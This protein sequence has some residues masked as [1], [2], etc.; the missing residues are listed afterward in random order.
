MGSEMCIRDS[1]LDQRHACT[2]IIEELRTP[3]LGANIHQIVRR[4]GRV[5][6]ELDLL[7]RHLQGIVFVAE[8]SVLEPDRYRARVC[9]W[10]CVSWCD[11]LRFCVIW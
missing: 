4:L 2:V 3:L 8:V 11:V 7:D 10:N 1:N 9:V 5:L 6:L